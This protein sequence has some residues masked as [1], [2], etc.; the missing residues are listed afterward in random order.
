V[1]QD[2]VADASAEVWA[3]LLAALAYVDTTLR[4]LSLELQG[5]VAVAAWA[6]HL[7]ALRSLTVLAEEVVIS[8]PLAELAHLTTLAVRSATGV[9]AF[10][11][12]ASLPPAL[13]HLQL[14]SAL[15]CALPAG[16]VAAAALRNCSLS[17]S[18][19][20]GGLTP[21]AALG[22]LQQLALNSCG[23]TRAPVELG[24]LTGLIALYLDGNDFSNS[25]AELGSLV[26]P[27]TRLRVLAA[28][29]CRLSTLPAALMGLA[30]LALYVEDNPLAAVPEG[31]ALASLLAVSLD[32][33]A[34]LRSPAALARAPRLR[35]LFVCRTPTPIEAWTLEH[36]GL[37]GAGGLERS[38]D[39]LVEAV[40]AHPSL[41]CVTFVSY[42]RAGGAD[43]RRAPY[44][45]AMLGIARGCPRLEAVDAIEDFDFF[46]WGVEE[47]RRE[48]AAAGLAEDA[49]E[50]GGAA[51][52]PGDV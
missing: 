40:R 18:R 36:P 13:A 26:A 7:T 6:R 17:G 16:L 24:A 21:L 22:G 28:S 34:L 2:A 11:P 3:A 41:H 31:P 9:A 45:D 42:E 35:R 27:L 32:W 5:P 49:G 52:F 33:H 8:A 46:A 15:P 20:L 25:S 51:Q 50:A 19:V 12:R 47:L 48:A 39:A 38:V 43:P 4:V 44:L 30:L 1:P 23:L 14:S 29:A 10:S 37:E